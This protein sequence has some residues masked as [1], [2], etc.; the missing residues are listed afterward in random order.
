MTSRIPYNELRIST[1]PD[2]FVTDLATVEDCDEA[3]VHLTRDI[4]HIDS[5]IIDEAAEEAATG[6]ATDLDWLAKAKSA[7]AVKVVIRGV[8]Q[9]RQGELGRAVKRSFQDSRDRKLLGLLKANAPD[10]FAAAVSQLGDA[11]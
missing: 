2:W 7:R 3:L 6:V 5:Q 8:V 10:A 4:A 1:D 9:R 11:S